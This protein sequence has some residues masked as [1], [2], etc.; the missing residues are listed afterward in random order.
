MGR[1]TGKKCSFVCANG[2]LFRVSNRNAA[3]FGENRADGEKKQ[4]LQG[5]KTGAAEAPEVGS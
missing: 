3:I 5:K 2:R 4:A 1:V